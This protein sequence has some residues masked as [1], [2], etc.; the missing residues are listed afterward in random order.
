MSLCSVAVAAPKK[1]EKKK[2]AAP[3][4]P[5]VGRPT[6]VRC[7]KAIIRRCAPP[8]LQNTMIYRLHREVN[9][10]LGFAQYR[11]HLSYSGYCSCISKNHAGLTPET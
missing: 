8:S 3:A 6:P 7:L 9:H 4:A 11:T 2:E 10:C 5:K 1:E